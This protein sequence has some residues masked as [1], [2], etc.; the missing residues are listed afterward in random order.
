MMKKGICKLCLK[1]KM[2]IEQSHI[3]PTFM[4]KG[5]VFNAKKGTMMRL[6]SS[7]KKYPRQRGLYKT[8]VQTGAFEKHILCEDC[9]NR[10]LGSNLEGYMN[11]E[12][13]SVVDRMIP[14]P[15]KIQWEGSYGI[16]FI[17]LAGLENDRLI[18]FFLSLLWRVSI[19][20]QDGWGSMR[21]HSEWNEEIRRC[22]MNEST[23]ALQAW[24]IVVI[25]KK[26]DSNATSDFLL[27]IGQ[28]D[29]Y[30]LIA[31]TYMIRFLR[32]DSEAAELLHALA[33]A[34]AISMSGPV[35]TC[36]ATHAMW[37]GMVKKVMKEI[38]RVSVQNMGY[39]EWKSYVEKLP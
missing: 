34:L 24:V 5:I 16:P 15:G 33:L 35:R 9:D 4:L 36:I 19:C 30:Q 37:D 6:S 38:A 10:R 27:P 17:E 23:D 18:R 32:R 39:D 31:G 1:E 21:L 26:P 2:L 3:I 11:R 8:E 14:V 12:F 25:R 29:G 7:P 28:T 20:N 22:L 13:F